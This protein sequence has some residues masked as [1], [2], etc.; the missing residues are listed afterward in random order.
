MK[1]KHALYCASGFALALAAIATSGAPAVAQKAKD[2]VRMGFVDPIETV[3]FYYDPK[4]ETSFLTRGVYTNLIDYN[5]EAG[6]FAPMMA[7]SWTQVN[8]TTLEFKL[9]SDVNFHDGAAFSA[10]DV[11][12]TIKWLIDPATKLRFKS[13]YD[14]IKNAEKI[15]ATTVRVI[16]HTPVAHGLARLAVSTPIL[17]AGAHGAFKD[18]ADFGRKPTG[19]GPYRAT[20]VDAN[21][22]VVMEKFDGFVMGD[23]RGKANIGRFEIRPMPEVQTQIAHF[24]RKEVDLLNAVPKDQVEAMTAN[25]DV[26]MTPSQ[27]LAYYYLM[28]DAAGRSPN[29]VFKDQR[30]R[31]AVSMAINRE[32]IVKNILDFGGSVKPIDNVCFKLQQ[33]CVYSAK[34]PA[35]D[36]AQAKKLLAEAG[37][38]GGFDLEITAQPE[39]YDLAEVIAGELRK[40]NIRATVDKRTMGTYRKKQMDGELQSLAGIFTSGGLPDASALLNFH[41]DG[42][43]RDYARDPQMTKGAEE[44]ERTMDPKARDAIY[45]SAFDRLNEMNYV[46]PIANKPTFWLHTKDVKVIPGS[47][48]PLGGEPTRV[49]WN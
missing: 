48:A 28:F 37:L 34:P 2:T 41:F 30:V 7:T 44:G 25:P 27:S 6:K 29:K 5:P 47:L 11:V 19:S 4:P 15:D 12:Y 21:S 42:G 35:Y 13:N 38:A 9:R 33:A 36:L 10:D 43:G 8:D 49:Q 23:V 24:I 39:V 1:T 17:P 26:R 20:S 18:K 16:S 45:K 31:Q 22:G 46:L 32:A 14:W 40:V 3:D